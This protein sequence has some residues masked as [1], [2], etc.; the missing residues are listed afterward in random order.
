MRCFIAVD[1]DESIRLHLKRIQ[2]TLQERSG[3]KTS[4]AKWVRPDSI[5]LTIKFLGEVRDSVL[6]EACS[7][8]EKSV[9]DYSPF[10]I[11]LA[12]IGTFGSPARIVWVGAQ[13]HPTLI[14]LQ[15]ELDKG[16]EPLGFLPES[17]SFSPHLTLCRVRSRSAGLKLSNLVQEIPSPNLGLLSVDSVCL[18]KSELTKT[19]P[20]YTVVSKAVLSERQRGA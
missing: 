7:V 20:I 4:D 3:I 14:G 17:R 18:Y 2:Y 16:F 5:H 11:A 13:D 19:G 15:K 10:S 12:G 6:P 8:L 9:A 1:L